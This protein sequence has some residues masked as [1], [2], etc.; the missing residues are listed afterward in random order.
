MIKFR[1]FFDLSRPDRRLLISATIALGA[2]RF[3]LWV[4]PFRFLHT[5][6]LRLER[7]R[8][9]F[10]RK[11]RPSVGRIVWAVKI[12]SPIVPS[13]T[14]LAQALATKL[15]LRRRGYD[16]ALRIGVTRNEAG[17][18]QAHAWIEYDG[19]IVLGYL[20][21]MSRYSKLPPLAPEGYKS[22]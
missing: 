4:I 2:V 19:D 14:C 22:E 10:Q 7:P 9:R 13:A 6:L 12:A 1:K 11:G 5:V 3:G 16:P 15:L 8:F 18:F 21:D 20:S 17:E